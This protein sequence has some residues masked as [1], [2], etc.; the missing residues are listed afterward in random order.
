MTRW[1]TLSFSLVL[2]STLGSLGV[3]HASADVIPMDV[4]ECDMHAVGSACSDPAGP[5]VCTMSTCTRLDYASWNQD[6]SLTPPSVTY[7][8]VRCIAGGSSDA[9]SVGAD[10][11]SSSPPPASSSCSTNGVRTQ[12]AWWI[13]MLAL[14]APLWASRRRR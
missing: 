13:A 11:G 9:G 10:A 8:C 7:D 12:S 4:T 2:F 1:H 3:S 5:G 14:T 6:A